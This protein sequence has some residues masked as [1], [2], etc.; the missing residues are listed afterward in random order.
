MFNFEV[1]MMWLELNFSY[2]WCFHLQE[3]TGFWTKP[4]LNTRNTQFMIFFPPCSK[5]DAKHKVCSD[6][7]PWLCLVSE[8]FIFCFRIWWHNLHSSEDNHA[9]I[10][11]APAKS[12]SWSDNTELRDSALSLWPHN[13]L[14]YFFL[15]LQIKLLNF[16]LS[17]QNIQ[18]ILRKA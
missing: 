13:N 4:V 7:S 18:H 17:T 5:G 1:H 6:F 12:I 3:S 16:N 14:W 2:L 15:H 10:T 11:G 9:K 8:L